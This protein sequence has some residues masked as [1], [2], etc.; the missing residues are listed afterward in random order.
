M[1]PTRDDLGGDEFFVAA[2]AAA[3]LRCICGSIENLHIYQ[4]FA[5]GSNPETTNLAV[6]EYMPFTQ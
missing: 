5:S 1:F 6:P 2:G 4:H 3:S